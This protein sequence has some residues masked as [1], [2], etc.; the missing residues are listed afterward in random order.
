MTTT[1]ETVETGG[2]SASKTR[3]PL[4][5][6]EDIEKTTDTSVVE[7]VSNQYSLSEKFIKR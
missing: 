1:E 5:I 7:E 3:K 2:I 4:D 6:I